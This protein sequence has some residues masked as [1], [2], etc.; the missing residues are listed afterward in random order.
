MFKKLSSISFL[1]ILIAANRVGLGNPDSSPDTTYIR[2]IL[3]KASEYRNNYPDSALTFSEKALKLALSSKDEAFI[4]LAYQ[5]QGQSYIQT[6]NFEKSTEALLKALR[7]EEKRE[8]RRRMADLN[9]DMGYIYYLMERFQTSLDYYNKSLQ[10][11]ESLNDSLGIAKLLS[12]IGSLHNSREFCETRT[13]EQRKIDSETA[14]DFYLR[15]AAICKKKNIHEGLNSAYV[16]LGNIYKKLRQFEVSEEY[17]QKAMDYY[18]STNNADGET[19]VYY[20]LARLYT[21]TKKYNKAIECFGFCE[22]ISKE[23]NLMHGIQFLYGEMANTFEKSGRYKQAFEY[24]VKY[25]TIRDSIYNAGKS[26]QIFEL[27]TKYQTEK[28]EKDILQLSIDKK[29]RNFYIAVLGAVLVIIVLAAWFILIRSRQRRLLVEKEAQIKEQKIKELEQLR[30]LEATQSVLNGEEQERRRL[31]RDL[32]DG[33]GGM[34]S[35][36]KLKL[37]NMKGN[38]I[39]D[40][41]GKAD[42]DKALEMLDGSVRELRQVAHNMM[43]EALIK[44]GLKDALSDFCTALDNPIGIN[45]KFKSYGEIHR[46]DQT[47]EIALYR[48][49]QELINNAIKHSGASEILVDLVQDEERVS[50]TVE[51]NGRG[52]DIN[53]ITEFKGMGLNSLKSRMNALNGSFDIMSSEGKGT[54]VKVEFSAK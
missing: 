4:S 39:L 27:E 33:L 25:M 31:A 23:H 24:Y 34:L 26:G 2:Q 35:G 32:H 54:E 53:K 36:I 51:D 16:N 20:N 17:L 8:D 44:F 46:V 40:E 11:Y 37:T 18:Q 5:A 29:R 21:I 43:P 10:F 50:L 48:V 1:V 41:T 3:T 47:I 45:I 38:F 12:H 13:E 42:F 6:E 14:L 19:N 52:F 9:D 49:A 22:R 28:K 15:S 7:I 30:M